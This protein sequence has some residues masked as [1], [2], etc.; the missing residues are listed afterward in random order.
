[1][2]DK[3]FVYHIKICDIPV[4]SANILK[5]EMLSMGADAALHRGALNGSVKTTHCLLLGHRAHFN[6]LMIKLRKQP[7]GLAR[8]G[9]EIRR[10]IR[11]YETGPRTWDMGARR[12]PVGSRTL[13]MGILNATPDSFSGDGILNA[14]PKEWVLK[15]CSMAREGADILDVGGEST[16]PGA[17][18]VSPR[19]ELRRVVPVLKA[20]RRAV[21]IPI[22]IDTSKSEVAHAALDLGALTVNDVSALRF[23]KKMARLIAR[24]KAGVILMHRLGESRTMQKNPRYRGD[25][26]AEIVTFLSDAIRRACD[27]GIAPGKIAV[28]PGVGFGKTLEHNLDI[29]R[30]LS[31]FKNLGRPICVGVSRKTFIGALLNEEPAGRLLGTAAAVAMAVSR[32]AHIVR[33][34]DV[35]EAKDVVRVCDAIRRAGR[36]GLNIS[37]RR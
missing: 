1:M 6:L 14:S 37:P 29:L 33:V 21:R 32:G 24:Y 20:I 2:R 16:R 31:E 8:L 7:F 5:Q 3:G 26:V 28:D 17:K 23:D 30:H 22:S 18:P 13:V 35:K 34:H 19:Q 12:L 27:A 10:T 4:F 11:D 36:Q 9:A 25:V 15:A